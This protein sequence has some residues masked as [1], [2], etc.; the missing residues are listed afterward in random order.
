MDMNMIATLIVA[1]LLLLVICTPIVLLAILI[2]RTN[3][4]KAPVNKVK[5]EQLEQND[6][7]IADDVNKAFTDFAAD[8]EKLNTRLDGL[9]EKL[10]RDASEIKGF[11]SKR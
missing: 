7:Q 1:F 11:N 9:E 3:K 8:L 5:L 2:V 10:D 6:Y 4:P